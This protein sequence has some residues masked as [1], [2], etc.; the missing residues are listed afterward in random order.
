M[1]IFNA[2]NNIID[3]YKDNISSFVIIAD[4]QVKEE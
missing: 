1:N 2:H 4:E 3:Q